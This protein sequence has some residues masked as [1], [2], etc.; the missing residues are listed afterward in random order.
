MSVEWI[1]EA[2]SQDK[3]SRKLQWLPRQPKF[4]QNQFGNLQFLLVDNNNGN[5]F[6]STFPII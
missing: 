4:D 1:E 6:G 5:I 3:R 2:S